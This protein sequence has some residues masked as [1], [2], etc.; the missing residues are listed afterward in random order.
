MDLAR[1]QYVLGEVPQE[2]TAGEVPQE[3]TAD[4]VLPHGFYVLGQSVHYRMGNGS[5]R[6]A[7]VV[8]VHHDDG[9]PYYTVCI[10]GLGE[11]CTELAQLSAHAEAR[12]ESLFP[13][14]VLICS[15]L[16]LLL[17]IT[18][19]SLYTRSGD[20][21]PSEEA[22]PAS[23][24]SPPPH[25]AISYYKQEA[26]AAREQVRQ[27]EA[28]AEEAGQ[29]MA[30]LRADTLEN[31]LAAME[32]RRLL[33]IERTVQAAEV[34][35]QA[36]A[37]ST[38]AQT[39]Y[40][41][42]AHRV[43]WMS[44]LVVVVAM[45]EIFRHRRK[46]RAGQ[47]SAAEA[48]AEQASAAEAA[49]QAMEAAQCAASAAVASAAYDL[50]LQR[51]KEEDA[52]TRAKDLE[53]E[54]RKSNAALGAAQAQLREANTSAQ[55]QQA[56]HHLVQARLRQECQQAEEQAREN[57]RMLKRAAER[58]KAAS[59]G[60]RQKEKELR[61]L[62]REVAKPPAHWSLSTKKLTQRFFLVPVR[63]GSNM[64]LWQTLQVLL[65][66]ADPAQLGK[67]RDVSQ[68]LRYN[69]LKLVSA[70]RIENGMLWGKFVASKKEVSQ[71]LSD[72]VRNNDTVKS[73][74]KLSGVPCSTTLLHTNGLPLRTTTL[75]SDTLPNL[76]QG[77]SHREQ[78]VLHGTR[79]ETLLQILRAGLNERYSGSSAGAAFGEGI[80]FAE[81]AG[82]SDQY[83]Q[84]D[85][86]MG[87]F[88]ELHKQLYTETC[89]S[90]CGKVQYILVCRVIL[91]HH[92]RTFERRQHHRSP[93]SIDDANGV[94]KVF[95]VTPRELAQIPGTTGVTHHSLLVESRASGF[96]QSDVDRFREIVI[97]HGDYCYP[98][99]LLAYQ[100]FDDA[101]GPI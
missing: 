39:Q 62:E 80:Y 23:P 65:S 48:R 100:R 63:Q 98:E 18:V 30:K 58:G 25:M 6:P 73:T 10:D 94:L 46:A 13:R 55:T 38:A 75:G 50:A 71:R 95:P 87:E 36:D 54:C 61:E 26:A 9:A 32:A 17:A 99:Y 101:R 59:S 76:D 56:D 19:G 83:V 78:L 81:D 68:R 35:I 97:F 74:S 40:K 5:T 12:P 31:E 88:P 44:I 85:K 16:I 64:A 57:R 42:S 67:G 20:K 37:Y 1:T 82:K 21:A 4:S 34:A 27:A 43:A 2:V 79:P 11:R 28:T 3:V 15:V 93:T 72:I 51:K 60:L 22:S 49:R 7:T 47:A 41:D 66:T 14:S 69:R 33:E 70:W 29:A 90:H 89:S 77:L 86:C 52:R 92:L 53:R 96:P 45:F 91:G 8:G 24:V 84:C